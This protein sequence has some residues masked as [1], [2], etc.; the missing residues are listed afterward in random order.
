M[1]KKIFLLI[2]LFSII[3]ITIAQETIDRTVVSSG[4]FSYTDP[5]SGYTISS[6]I[7]EV[8]VGTLPVG[9][10][11]DDQIMFT[12]GFQQGKPPDVKIV[13]KYGSDIDVKIYPNP[14]TNEVNILITNTSITKEMVLEI[15]DMSGK[16]LI[17]FKG[18]FANQLYSTN[19]INDL[20]SGMY[21][22]RISEDNNILFRANIVK[23]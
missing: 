13:E 17:N 5:V 10:L 6:T 2:A 12:Q 3:K 20:S 4:G 1:N 22:F 7:G 14:M 9:T 21:L 15:F 16:L 8:F 19:S 11:T 18:L 23:E